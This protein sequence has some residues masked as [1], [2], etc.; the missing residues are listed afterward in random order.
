M[1]DIVTRGR[2]EA[3]I[4]GRRISIQGEG[5]RPKPGSGDPD[6][7]VF[8]PSITRWADGSAVTEQ[9]LATILDDLRACASAKGIVL[10]FE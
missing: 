5:Y 8:T 1:F 2:I 6:F 7:V 10:D 4:N 9:D 3:E